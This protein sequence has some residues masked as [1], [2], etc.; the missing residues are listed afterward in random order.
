MATA[1]TSSSFAASTSPISTRA[2]RR[3]RHLCLRVSLTASSSVSV[4]TTLPSSSL[5]LKKTAPD[6]LQYESGFLGGISENTQ[7]LLEGDCSA[8]GPMEY[9]TSI[10]SSKVYD[11]AAET[12]LELAP[13]LSARLGVNF[14]IKREDLQQ[15]IYLLRP[16]Y[17]SLSFGSNFKRDFI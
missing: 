17:R 7:K 1:A 11:V 6:S 9:L 12:P 4:S 14:Y 8:L 15:V 16:L 5:S 2:L 10:L 13:K 3:R